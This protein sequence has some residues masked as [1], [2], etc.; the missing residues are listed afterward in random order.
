[1]DPISLG[2]F[3]IGAFS[4]TFQLFS[5]CVK[6]YNL[7][8]DANGM[9]AQ[10][11]YLRVRL[12]IEQHRLLNWADVANLTEQK[13]F[14]C[15][16]PKLSEGLVQEVL[17]E[18]EAILAS[19]WKGGHP[20]R[21]LVDD[22]KAG[23]SDAM[24]E[25]E[26][27]KRFPYAKGSLEARALRCVQVIRQYPVRMRWAVFD[28][29]RFENMLAQLGALNDAMKSLLDS[30]QQLTLHQAQTRT[31]IQIL[32]LNNKVDYL[33]QIFEAGNMK[34]PIAQ[35]SKDLGCLQQPDPS[36]AD[37]ELEEERAALT[38]LARFKALNISINSDSSEEP[39]PSCPTTREPGP[40]DAE[41]CTI[42]QSF[43]STY[44]T[45]IERSTGLYKGNSVWI[46]WK[47]YDPVLLTGHPSS[48][49]WTRIA[50][51]SALLSDSHG[52]KQFHTPTCVGYFNDAPHNRLGLVFC[53]PTDSSSAH[54]PA[55]L[56]DLFLADEKPSL[57]AR[58]HLAHTL[59]T[60]LQYLHSTNWVHKALRSQNVVF[61]TDSGSPDLSSPF[62]SGFG[63]AR[64]AHNIE[65]TER[66]DNTPLYNLY[67][68]PLAH[69]DIAP[70]GTGGFKKTFDI[71]SL[72]IVL[73]E[74]SLWKP[75]NR[76]L[77]I[78]SENV[79]RHF[80]PGATKKIRATLL[81]EGRFLSLVR[82]AA[83]NI[84]GDVV[85]VCLEGF[86]EGERDIE[87]RFHEEVVLRLGRISL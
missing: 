49:T 1:M 55:S 57:T 6:A 22:C 39:S 29:E 48:C 76:V 24:E 16:I 45:E 42:L 53:C 8:S 35:L 10:F 58:V 4:L 80:L 82:A 9:P 61:F 41:S 63:L 78:E 5:A 59:A 47:Y 85:R 38:T 33:L 31:S 17:R 68:H 62:L 3:C 7:L 74:V 81:Q 77:G 15:G 73:L 44:A 72:G 50:K 69:G 71:Y 2:S 13:E 37:S 18:Q 19:F 79:Q 14:L 84:L 67:R 60:A 75:L 64:P 56:F 32:H 83:G 87:V 20:Y 23:F 28:R 66:P 30:Q 12:K 46:D 27:Q 36:L 40:L 26:L 11:H 70:E 52:L 34:L 86:G 54:A 25:V 43:S 21:F 51:L 65:M